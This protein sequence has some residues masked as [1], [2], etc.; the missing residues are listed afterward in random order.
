MFY[1]DEDARKLQLVLAQRPSLLRSICDE[2]GGVEI[3]MD[4]MPTTTARNRIMQDR[5]KAEWTKQRYFCS[6]STLVRERAITYSIGAVKLFKTSMESSKHSAS[7]HLY[8][9]TEATTTVGLKMTYYGKLLANTIRATISFT[10]GAGG[11]SISPCLRLR[12][13]VSNPSPAFQLL[14]R[15]ALEARF[16]DTQSQQTNELCQHFE[17]VLQELYELFHAKVASPTDISEDGNTLITV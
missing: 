12:A 14:D 5:R 10:N 11:I 3:D 1:E 4:R 9:G 17:N 16:R 8:I 6:C 7:C 2:V 13:L 15:K